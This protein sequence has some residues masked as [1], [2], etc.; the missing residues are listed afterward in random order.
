MTSWFLVLCVAVCPRL[1]YSHRSVCVFLPLH[2]NPHTGQHPS[3][4]WCVLPNHRRKEAQYLH[5]LSEVTRDILSRGVLS[6]AALEILFRS[7]VESKC[8]ELDK[9]SKHSGPGRSIFIVSSSQGGTASENWRAQIA[10]R[11]CRLRHKHWDISALD[12][13]CALYGTWL[14]Q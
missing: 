13:I 3:I 9:V 4:M 8:H 14:H 5:F 12:Q 11:H 2:S 7:H 10:A 1:P 6:K